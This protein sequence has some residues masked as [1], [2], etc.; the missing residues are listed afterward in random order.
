[1]SKTYKISSGI[2]CI[3][4]KQEYEVLMVEKKYTYSFCDF[5]LGNYNNTE[6]ILKKMFNEMTIYEKQIIL[7]YGFDFCWEYIFE[8]EDYDKS[9]S[10][11]KYNKVSNMYNI[12]NMIKESS[13]I[14]PIWEF[15]KGRVEKNENILQ[16]AKR[17]FTEETGIDSNNLIF[18]FNNKFQYSIKHKYIMYDFKLITALLQ[19]NNENDIFLFKNIT[20]EISNIKWVSLSNLDNYCSICKDY[21]LEQIK[22]INTNY[23]YLLY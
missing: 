11:N 22:F 16:T 1:M 10:K 9:I 18:L 13:S 3:R 8:N 21:I 6:P 17:E 15:P 20:N 23:K 7:K 2:I 14:H 5:I 19:N 4:K 12:L